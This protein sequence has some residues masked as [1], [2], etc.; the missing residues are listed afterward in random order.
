MIGLWWLRPL[1]L[2]LGIACAGGAYL[3]KARQLDEARTEVAELQA[4]IARANE[5]AQA[6]A[7]EMQA[8]VT[9]AQNDATKRESILRAS[10]ND[11]RAESDGLRDDIAAM[12]EQLTTATRDAAAARAIAVGTVLQQCAAKYQDMAAIADRHAS[13]VRTLMQ[14]WPK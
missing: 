10:A 3:V 6:K 14:A 12:R 13:D 5:Q 2:A 9:R 1:L 7:A 8:A 11:A 4:A